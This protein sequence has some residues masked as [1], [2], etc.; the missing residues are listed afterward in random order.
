MT[1]PGRRTDR[2]RGRPA[3]A[4]SSVRTPRSRPARTL[5]AGRPRLLL[6]GDVGGTKTNI[7][8]Y[9]AGARGVVLVDLERYPSHEHAGLGE[10]VDTF[11]GERRAKLA[12]AAFGIAGPVVD[13]RSHTTNLPWVI[14]ARPLS[15]RMGVPV[16]LVNDLAATA[17]SL[18]EVGPR[19]LA[20]L[21]RGSPAKEGGL[22]LI[23]AGTG[24]G[25]AFVLRDGGRFLVGASEGGHADYAP[26]TD[27]EIDLL[28]FLRT[29]F[30]RASV[31]R[32]LSGPGL[33][34]IDAFLASREPGSGPAAENNVSEPSRDPA[35]EIAQAA[36]GR[37]SARSVHAL[38][39]FVAAY[40]AEAGNLALKCL[41]T[42][43]VYL[44]G[45]IAPKIL[46]ALQ[47]GVFLEAFLAKGRFRDLLVSVPVHVILDDHAA[48][49]GAAR[50]ARTLAKR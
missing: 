10:M 41:A 18:P 26:R 27:E 31:E 34:N 3:A 44:G 42:G 25:E 5:R 46:P 8:L 28:R 14:D 15:R 45:G 32:V 9:E 17:W 37:R 48:L 40:G 23:A 1:S 2:R 36:L 33:V 7:A 20:T 16:A 50:I 12:A 49:L 11:L 21:Q 43:G 38:R 29:R 13:R 4:G 19:R 39:L 35:A 30:G 24:L 22:A 47:E 6:A